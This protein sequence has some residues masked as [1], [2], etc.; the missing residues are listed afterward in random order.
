MARV[1]AAREGDTPIKSPHFA[2]RPL[3]ELLDQLKVARSEKCSESGPVAV[4]PSDPDPGGEKDP[5]FIQIEV[6]GHEGEGVGWQAG[7][8]LVRLSPSEAKRRLALV[9]QQA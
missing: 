1:Y 7:W 5:A 4:T 9:F 6:E 8:H 2:E 3:K